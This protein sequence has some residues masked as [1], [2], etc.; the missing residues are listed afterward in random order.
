MLLH[1][2]KYSWRVLVPLVPN[3]KSALECVIFL[4][5][6][7]TTVGD[8]LVTD[9]PNLD[10][11]KRNTPSSPN[12]LH[13]RPTK[14]MAKRVQSATT[15]G[16][17][18]R[19]T[20]GDGK[21][22]PAVKHT[23]GT[24]GSEHRRLA[25]PYYKYN[26]I[27]HFRCLVGYDLRETCHVVQHLLRC[28]DK[29]IH[30]RTCGQT[31]SKEDEC[32]A[33][34]EARSCEQTEFHHPG[35]DDDQRKNIR[36]SQRRRGLNE[37]GRWFDLWGILFP[38]TPRP[39]SPYVGSHFEV[40]DKV[41]AISVTSHPIWPPESVVQFLLHLGCFPL[42]WLTFRVDLQQRHHHVRRPVVHP[43][44]AARPGCTAA[45]RLQKHGSEN[46]G[47]AAELVMRVQDT[48]RSR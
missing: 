27:K 16:K 18:T 3:I 40:V 47:T 12:S 34:I 31:F 23:P 24:V 17:R 19:G 15:R 7:Y 28:H 22:I 26:P 2:V 25:C 13:D 35:M 29:P 6:I 33:H 46:C 30:C 44:S 14:R 37:V 38:D 20:K 39:D 11:P 9:S 21:S 5:I 1:F 10:P 36:D 4:T 32:N 48:P 41:S 43:P 45:I 42:R 8:V